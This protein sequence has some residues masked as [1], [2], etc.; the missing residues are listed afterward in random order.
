ML[1]V[2]GTAYTEQVV[3][4]D[5]VFTGAAGVAWTVSLEPQNENANER[6]RDIIVERNWFRA[7]DGATQVAL[8]MS[9]ANATIRNN[10]CDMSGGFNDGQTC[11][12]VSRRGIEP[13]PINARIYNN[14]A[15]GGTATT[16]FEAVSLGSS[17]TGA[18]VINNLG[19]APNAGARTMISG[20]PSGLV[21]S[22]N[23]LNNTPANL[24]V[25]ASP[26]VPA[27]FALKAG[28]PASEAGGAVP[29]HSDFFRNRRPKGDAIDVG[30][31]EYGP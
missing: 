20:S 7:T 28:S 30:A 6:L 4:S 24:F 9:A 18:A 12:E 5:N 17:S 15:Y 19:S 13:N 1:A 23:I 27:N 21:Q 10:I 22:N 8:L 14:T 31:T 26:T 3:I 29:V 25:T 11:Y 2:E 16:D